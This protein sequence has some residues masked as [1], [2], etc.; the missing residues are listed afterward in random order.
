MLLLILQEVLLE[1]KRKKEEGGVVRGRG[2]REEGARE[3]A[4]EGEGGFHDKSSC[5]GPLMYQLCLVLV[6]DIVGSRVSSS[7]YCVQ[8]CV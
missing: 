1:K 3:E 7:L 8:V 4:R 6:T 5:P 2:E